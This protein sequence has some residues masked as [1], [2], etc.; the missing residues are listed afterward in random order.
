VKNTNNLAITNKFEF[1]DAEYLKSKNEI[2][3]NAYNPKVMNKLMKLIQEKIRYKCTKIDIHDDNGGNSIDNNDK[4]ILKKDDISFVV[5]DLGT[6]VYIYVYMY[7][8][9]L[10]IFIHK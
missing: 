1:N 4:N 10:P 5:V 6:H 2:D 3:F 8:I 7:I 9:H